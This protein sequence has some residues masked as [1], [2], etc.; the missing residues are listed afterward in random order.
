MPAEVWKDVACFLEGID[1]DS[2]QFTTLF[3]RDFT[4]D[5]RQHLPMRR[6]AT[7]EIQTSNGSIATDQNGRT[8]GS[9]SF[10]GLAYRSV[11][12][13]PVAF[14]IDVAVPDDLIQAANVVRPISDRA[15]YILRS[16]QHSIVEDFRKLRQLI[17]KHRHSRLSVAQI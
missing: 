17:A 7:A 8:I 9:Y 3:H 15:K 11:I 12:L 14:I 2:L 4:L 5:N 6:L 1:V 13:A 10:A 16:L